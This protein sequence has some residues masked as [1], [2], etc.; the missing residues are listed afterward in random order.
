MIKIEQDPMRNLVTI[1]G[2]T[3][4][5]EFFHEWA[6]CPEGVPILLKIWREDGIVK[7]DF[8]SVL[9]KSEM[10]TRPPLGPVPE[11]VRNGDGR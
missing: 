10:G 3:F 5:L 11:W 2:V 4:G 6:R 7:C 1:D 8:Y 9:D